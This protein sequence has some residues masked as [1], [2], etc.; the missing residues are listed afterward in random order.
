MLIAKAS[1]SR[2]NIKA[3]F[4]AHWVWAFVLSLGLH[5]VLLA[6]WPWAAGLRFSLNPPAPTFFTLVAQ[7][8]KA[9][10]GRA[11]PQAPRKS[12]LRTTPLILRAEGVPSDV[13]AHLG[14]AT[15]AI[16]YP[17]AAR[18]AKEEGD[19]FLHL[20]ILPSGQVGRIEVLPETVASPRLIK[21]ALR[22]MAQLQIKPANFARPLWIK[23]LVQFRLG[24]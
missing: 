19:V 5:A 17:W 21:A 6:G 1:G 2:P 9:T 4:D 20:E 22:G 16:I 8:V 13:A 18:L 23:H 3:F 15:A 7:T 24:Q 14:N 11:A 12:P 10:P